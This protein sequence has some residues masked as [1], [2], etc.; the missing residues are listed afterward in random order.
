MIQFAPNFFTD[1]CVQN[2]FQLHKICMEYWQTIMREE[3]K[4]G[5]FADCIHRC[6]M[7]CFF[8]KHTFSR[9]HE[10]CGVERAACEVS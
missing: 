6:C 3:R 2:S 10:I 1:S 5:L 9:L 8:R 7:A 4:S